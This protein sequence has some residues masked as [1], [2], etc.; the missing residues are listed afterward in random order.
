MSVANDYVGEI[1]I[2][3]T[4]GACFNHFVILLMLFS[5]ITY[6]QSLANKTLQSYFSNRKILSFHVVVTWFSRK[7][8]K[9]FHSWPYFDLCLALVVLSKKTFGV[10]RSTFDLE[11]PYK[12]SPKVIWCQ[13]ENPGL[14]CSLHLAEISFATMQTYVYH[15]HYNRAFQG[16]SL[17]MKPTL[18]FEGHVP[19]QVQIRSISF[20][21]DQS[22]VKVSY[23][24]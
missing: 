3:T 8:H 6:L 4:H 1:P 9:M 23:I 11:W 14:L 18:R 22:H 5:S 10:Q 20:C 16:C 15:L 7:S 13:S 19:H 24:D 2:S 21:I 17:S 12:L